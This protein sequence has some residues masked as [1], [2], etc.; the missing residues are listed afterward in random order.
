MDY[1]KQ[2]IRLLAL[3]DSPN[4]VERWVK[5]LRAAGMPPRVQH[6]SSIET[7]ENALKDQQWDLILSAEETP[8][9]N[10]QHVLNIVAK[11]QQD[12]PVIVTLPEYNPEKT[13]TWLSAGARDAIP[14][15]NEKHILH[16]VLRELNSLDDRRKLGTTLKS[17]EE[18]NK[19][20][21]LL[22]ASATEA[23][24]YIHD[25]MH[26]DANAAYLE[27]VGYDDIDDLAGTTIIDLVDQQHQAEIKQRLKKFNANASQPAIECQLAHVDGNYTFVS[28]QL[29]EA[30]YDDEPCIQLTLLPIPVLDQPAEKKSEIKKAPA[31][32]PAPKKVTT[33]KQKA[34]TKAAPAKPAQ[35]PQKPLALD[36]KETFRKKVDT[37]LQK[38]E[39]ATLIFIQLDD[40]EIL[41]NDYSDDGIRSLQ[42]A[43]GELILKKFANAIGC[44][45]AEDTFLLLAPGNPDKIYDQLVNLQ[46]TIEN[47]LFGSADETITTTATIGYAVKAGDQDLA[48]LLVDAKN[49][50][51]MALKKE[52]PR[53]EQYSKEKLLQEKADDGDV[54]A[55]IRQALSQDSFHLLYQP[56]I[57]ITGAEEEQYEVLLRLHSPKGEVIEASEFMAAAESS[58]L[59]PHI[60]RWVIRQCIRQLTPLYKAGKRVKLLIHLSPLSIQDAELVGFLTGL[61]KA[62][63]IPADSIILQ[64]PESVVLQQ[65]KRVVEFSKSIESIG[66]QLAITRFQSD[67]RSMKA[68][69]HL[70]VQFVRF[71]GSFTSELSDDRDEEITEM[72]GQ[73]REQNVRCIVPMV[74]SSPTLAHLWRLG[75]DYAQG[76]YISG[77]MDAMDFDFG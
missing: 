14:N 75:V 59:M 34:N 33:P 4:D 11:Y 12:I 23:I 53:I 19:R 27:L 10:A 54:Q 55:M 57:N 31:P 67:S 1:R 7:M 44:Q 68:L 52:N 73:L 8:R 69:K 17:L 39:Q 43:A 42:S 71:D 47:H 70:N 60:D 77:P 37:A 58:S 41:K 61:L 65:L 2:T 72:L 40:F 63:S 28:L 50:Y 15:T 30:E 20:C 16:A 25:G 64:M 76:Y 74:E 62:S 51:K 45:Y 66:C 22:L 26:V 36:A 49:A 18:S 35:K 32:A 9:L 6:I 38:T 21:Q 46:E 24:A 3:E 56:V 29:S 48:A 5:L 13:F